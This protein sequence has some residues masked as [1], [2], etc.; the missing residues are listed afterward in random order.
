LFYVLSGTIEI[1][2]RRLEA[3]DVVFIPKG[4]AYGARVLSDEGSRVLRIEIPN[5]D[6]PVES[7]EYEARI[8]QGALTEEGVPHLGA[9]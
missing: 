4:S 6:A 8:W 9:D 3:G 5:M 7:P 2:G 1:D